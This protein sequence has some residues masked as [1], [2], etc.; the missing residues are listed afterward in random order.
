MINILI[1]SD[2]LFISS[3]VNVLFINDILSNIKNLN[4]N[5]IYYVDNGCN[6]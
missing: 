2:D 4:M 3:S 6:K 1:V 5:F